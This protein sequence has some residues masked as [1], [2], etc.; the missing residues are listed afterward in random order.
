MNNAFNVMLTVFGYTL[1][2]FGN[3]LQKKGVSCLRWKGDRDEKFRTNLITW[4]SGMFLTY[5]LSMI[6]TG[7]ASKNLP[8]YVVSAV[9]GLNISL[10]IIL[11]YF[12]LKEK[13]YTS[14]LIYSGII[15]VCIF[16]TGIAQQEYSFNGINEMALYLFIFVPFILLIPAFSKFTDKKAKAILF[17]CFGGIGDGLAVVLINLCV[18]E[19]GTSVMGYLT[20][21]YLYIYVFI[22][23][24]TATSL[25]FAFK[26]GELVMV[27]PI[28]SSINIIY[29]IICSYFIFNLPIN[30]IQVVTITTI[31][32]SC[33]KIQKKR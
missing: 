8:P 27:A 22:G 4:L 31:I 33:Y 9:S 10:V 17:A 28:Q 21:P 7:I 14:D 18:K 26:N 29:P 1:F 20:S 6:P 32:F 24:A 23:I 2:A 3:V 30:N 5:I 11:S 16:L 13:L 15:F 19:F 12:I 25:Q